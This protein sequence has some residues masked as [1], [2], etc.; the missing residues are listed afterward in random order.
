MLLGLLGASFLGNVL[1]GKGVKVKISGKGVMRPGEG[2][3][4]AGKGMIGKGQDFQCDLIL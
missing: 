1:T 2:T 3:I 4:T